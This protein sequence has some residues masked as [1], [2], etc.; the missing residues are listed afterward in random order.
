[1]QIDRSI[2][3]SD[4]VTGHVV[5]VGPVWALLSVISEGAPNG[6]VALRV[7]DIVAVEEAP[8][9]RFVQRGLESLA[10]WPA[11]A[12]RAQLALSGTVCELVFSAAAAFPVLTL[13]VEH[14]DPARIVIGRPVGRAGE[15]LDWQE[16]TVEA[17]WA[18]IPTSLD[19]AQITR[20][21]LGGQYEKAL[22]RVSDL[23]G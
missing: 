13:Y 5:A 3:G 19:S 17:A 8:G 4:R 1:M 6:W 16:M 9:A 23:R 2:T 15:Q 21:D 12:P 22:N 18:E 11:V 14:Q 20:L 10:A 7:G